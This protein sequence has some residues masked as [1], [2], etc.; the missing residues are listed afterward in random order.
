MYGQWPRVWL[1]FQVLQR[2]VIGKL[3][4][5]YPKGE[6]F[7]IDHSEWGKNMKISVLHINSHYTV[8][9]VE[10]GFNKVI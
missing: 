2:Y 8:L 3:V 6:V 7:W 9:S 10:E 1:G 4:A 5:K